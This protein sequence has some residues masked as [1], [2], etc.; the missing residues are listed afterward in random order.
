MSKIS[1]SSGA[2]NV[3][4]FQIPVGIK[5]RKNKLDEV[6]RR[7]S[8]INEGHVLSYLIS[9]GENVT[10]LEES[11]DSERYSEVADAVREHVV[12]EAVK[13]K[14]KN[15]VRR[16]PGGGYAIYKAMPGNAKSEPRGNYPNKAAAKRALAQVETDPDRKA[17]LQKQVRMLQKHPEKNIGKPIPKKQKQPP[18]TAHIPKKP[19][20]KKE[21]FELLRS[22]ISV[23]I[24]E[25]LFREQ[26]VGSPWD[27]HL[28][29]IP[30][31]A[32]AKDSKFQSLQKKI[33]KATETVLKDA[34]NTIKKEVRQFA[35]VDGGDLSRTSDGRTYL[36]FSAKL[37]NIVVEQ[38]YIYAESGIPRVE[39]SPQADRGLAD[40]ERPLEDAF[41][42]RIASLQEKVFAKYTQLAEAVAARDSYLA[43]KQQEATAYLQKLTPLE[44]V[45][46]KGVIA[47]QFRRI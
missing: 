15:I 6:I 35:K 36:V 2:G 33:D 22:T 21:E 42:G 41:R 16:K 32:L 9:L 40:A 18:K 47:K 45:L 23:L 13:N 24:K 29:N 8:D 44:L 43:K 3:A 27:Q 28:A 11:L 10:A 37:G 12:R 5:K 26:Q 46:L 31:E 34:F 39:F 17:R 19:K 4:G 14:I 38:V 20:I 25:A 7:H 1:E 30:V